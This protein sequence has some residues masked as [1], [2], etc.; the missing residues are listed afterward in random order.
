MGIF[1][2]DLVYDVEI[3][4]L[5]LFAFLC[6]LAFIIPFYCYHPYTREQDVENQDEYTEP[7]TQLPYSYNN[8]NSSR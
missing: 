1:L 6:L 7:A 5:F 4:F 3:G 2:P 8:T